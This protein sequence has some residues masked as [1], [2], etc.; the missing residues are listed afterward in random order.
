MIGGYFLF[1]FL[2]FLVG[3]IIFF[4]FLRHPLLSRRLYLKFLQYAR[5]AASLYPVHQL[6]YVYQPLISVTVQLVGLLYL[7]SCGYE[8]TLM[9][10]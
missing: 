3:L 7:D 9:I 5:V 4:I 2:L 1:F 8:T 6:F 10:L